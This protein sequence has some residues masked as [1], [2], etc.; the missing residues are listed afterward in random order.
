[1]TA[2]ERLREEAG[3]VLFVGIDEQTPSEGLRAFLED[4]RPGGVILFARNIRDPAQ[5]AALTAWLAGGEDVPRLV[6]VDQEG[7][8]VERLRPLLGPLPAAAEVGAGSPERV[9]AFAR[10]LG[11]S[12]A[13]LG[14]H[15]DFAPVLDLSAPGAPNGI[16]DRSFGTDPGR[17]GAAGRAFLKGL[18]GAGVL[19]VGKHF[20]GLGPT[21]VDSHEA[22]PSVAK[23]GAAFR[24]E[25]LL[26]FRICAAAAPA[27]MI[28]HAHYACLDPEPRPASGSPAVIRGLLRGELGYDGVAIADDLEMGAVDQGEGWLA[29]AVS[30]LAAGCD[31]VLVCHTRPRMIRLRDEI[32]RQVQA[33]TLPA[34]RLSEAARRV[35]SLRLRAGE[36]PEAPPFAAARADLVEAFGTGES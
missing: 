34:S 16:G 29:A 8:R 4:V 32:V 20:P 33:G 24:R 18:A 5:T 22:R 17:V 10:L 35:R 21:S 30:S 7:G 9:A 19:G 25:D 1:M 2:I 23:D 31:Q 13:A 15:V 28:G 26:P 14:F 12:L 3:Q 6:G 27:V 11:R 36:R